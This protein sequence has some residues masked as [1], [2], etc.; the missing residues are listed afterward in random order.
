MRFGWIVG[1]LL[2]LAALAAVGYETFG[3]LSGSGYRLRALGELWF[4]LDPASLNIAQAAIQRHVWPW[5]WDGV[6]LKLLLV[7]AWAF[8]GA[9]GI[10]LAWGC[11]RRRRRR[12]G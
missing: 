3:W 12:A 6:A 11:R 10:L 8:F 1:W 7:P 5:L 2:V 9:P 4:E